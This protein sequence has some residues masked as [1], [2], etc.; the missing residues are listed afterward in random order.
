MCWF[1]YVLPKTSLS[2]NTPI[3]FIL[4][5]VLLPYFA[6]ICQTPF[7]SSFSPLSAVSLFHSADQR[8]RDGCPSHKSFCR[9]VANLFSVG[10]KET[11]KE[12][13]IYALLNIY[14][15]VKYYYSSHLTDLWPSEGFCWSQWHF[16]LLI[17]FGLYLYFELKPIYL[18][19]KNDYK[20]MEPT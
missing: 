15:V 6:L 18:Q 2:K 19:I 20:Q 17:K 1:S 14:P 12:R 7:V 13:R 3:F 8:F 5:S 10:Q 9:E 4:S 16:G 11:A